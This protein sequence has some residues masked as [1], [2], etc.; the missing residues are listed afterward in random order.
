MQGRGEIVHRAVSES[1]GLV[2]AVCVFKKER[3]KGNGGGREYLPH[4]GR[5][6]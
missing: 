6:G 4:C 1:G 3:E 2:L 5:W